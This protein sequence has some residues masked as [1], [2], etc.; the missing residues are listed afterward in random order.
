MHSEN[1]NNVRQQSRNLS[2][3]QKRKAKNMHRRTTPLRAYAWPLA[4]PQVGLGRAHAS[5]Y[6][7]ALDEFAAS[8]VDE[9][10]RVF[11]KARFVRFLS[12]MFRFDA[13]PLRAERDAILA[14]GT[15][16]PGRA[17]LR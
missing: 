10:T 1:R 8:A 7:R 5:V 9:Q 6:S 13:D 11:G 16:D 3:N 17:R 15:K 12:S 2:N 4:R 14:E